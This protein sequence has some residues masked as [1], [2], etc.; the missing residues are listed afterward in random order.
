MVSPTIFLFSWFLYLVWPKLLVI[1]SFRPE[2]PD[3][4]GRVEAHPDNK[5]HNCPVP[6]V[7][8]PAIRVDC[9]SRLLLLDISPG[10]FLYQLLLHWLSMGFAHNLAGLA[11]NLYTL[12]RLKTYQEDMCNRLDSVPNKII[13]Q[14]IW[15]FQKKIFYSAQMAIS[16]I[17]RR[18]NAYIFFPMR[19][20][21]KT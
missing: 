8:E 5:S 20:T 7:F 11:D 19:Y 21:S 10:L 16:T 13:E 14:I 18:R 12:E 17:W 9:P 4:Q 1:A 2:V 15:E 3:G 6:V